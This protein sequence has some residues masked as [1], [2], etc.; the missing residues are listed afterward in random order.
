MWRFFGM[1]VG[2]A[3]PFLAALLWLICAG[4]FGWLPDWMLR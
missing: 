4:V 3:L 2:P 1:D